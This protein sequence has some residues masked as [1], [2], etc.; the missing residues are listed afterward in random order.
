MTQDNIKLMANGCDTI[1]LTEY[2]GGEPIGYTKSDKE[3]ENWLN[4]D[5][6]H[7]WFPVHNVEYE[8]KNN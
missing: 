6:K 1:A 5:L 8:I 3:L 7:S 4:A 2:E